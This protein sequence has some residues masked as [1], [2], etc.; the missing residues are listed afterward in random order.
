MARD[1][2]FDEWKREQFRK[3]EKAPRSGGT[4]SPI[5]P[6]S[7]TQRGP[8]GPTGP[9][10]FNTGRSQY[11]TDPRTQPNPWI[12]DV[13]I[14]SDFYSPMQPLWPFGPPNVTVPRE[15]DYPIGYNLNYIPQRIELMAML[16][17]MR[18][19]WGVLATIISTRQDQL[20]RIPWTIQR[21]DKPRQGS[22]AVDEMKAFFKKPDRKLRYSQWANKLLDDLL[23]IDAPTIFFARDRAGRPLAAEVLD[24]ATIF[25]LIDDTGRR[26]D[27]EVEW[28]NGRLE[29]VRRQP[30]FQQIVKGLPLLD[31]D[32]SEIMYVP[33]RPRPHLPIFGYPGTEQ[34][35]IEASE[36]IRKTFY[37]LNFWQEGTIPDLV[38]TVPETWSARHI[39]MFQGHFDAMLSGNLKLKSKVRFLPGG[40]KPFDVKN[41]SGESLWSQRDETLIRLA[42]YAYSVSPT[43]F[44]KQVNRSVAQNAQE[45][46]EQEGLYPL[47]AFWKDNII[48][49]IIQEKFGYEDVEMIFLPRPERD[50]EKQ[51]TIHQIQLRNGERSINEVRND[52]GFEPIEGGEV[53]TIQLGNAIIPVKDAASGAAMPLG[54][55]GAEGSRAATDNRPGASQTPSAP[56]SQPQRGQ[57]RADHEAPVE[58]LLKL[59]SSIEV[60]SEA[61]NA[62]GDVRHHSGRRLEAGNYK[63]G[64]LRIAG[65]D[66]SIENPYGSVRGKK[67][68]AGDLAWA[69]DMPAHYGYIRGTVGADGDQLDIFIGRRPD[70]TEKIWI[71]DQMKQTKKGNTKFDEHKCFIG[72]KSSK[73]VLKDYEKAYGSRRLFGGLTEMS[74]TEFKKWIRSGQLTKPL[75]KADTI[76]SSTGLVNNFSRRKKKSRIRLNLSGEL[77]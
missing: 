62:D 73:R 63:K 25:P 49:P 39:A 2:Q 19:S 38:V 16:R 27:S 15:W 48:D 5:S 28:I 29:Y 68:P 30:A 4:I 58:K 52:L 66:I 31:F 46:A 51:A 77:R 7:A 9:T 64:H 6:Y 44:I 75:A 21:R 37:Q 47:M 71:I 36:A 14:A 54:S 18:S 26:P 35:L 56:N 10:P 40:M 32:E 41:S 11:A 61:A 24:G 20:L 22:V 17:G 72:Y 43:P 50:G 33:M 53:Y 76:S 8:I 70:L 59:L 42:A 65:L 57:P 60:D 55:A 74:L 3:L 1:L 12:E 45:S 13:D 34:I 67:N 23:V 69:S